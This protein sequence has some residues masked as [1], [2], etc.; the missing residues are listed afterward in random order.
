MATNPKKKAGP[1][2]GRPATK[3]KSAKA[4]VKKTKKVPAKAAKTGKARKPNRYNTLR[5]AI[6]QYCYRKYKHKCSN[7]EINRIYRELKMRYFDVD[8]SK[9]VSPSELAR[10][11][12]DKLGFKDKDN[13]PDDLKT[14]NWFDI[15]SVL[16]GNDK[17]FFKAGDRIEIQ[18]SGLAPTVRFDISELNKAYSDTLYPVMRKILDE[19]EAQF[20]QRAS[21][22]PFFAFDSKESNVKKRQF[23]WK[24]EIDS[25]AQAITPPTPPT[26]PQTPA[27]APEQPDDKD[28]EIA[29][30]QAREK[31]AQ[32]EEKAL[33]A[34]LDLIREGREL[35]KEGIITP[36][37]FKRNFM[38][39]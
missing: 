7:E 30:L 31:A 14:F 23:V 34:R 9:Q 22:P 24:L 25:G 35:L 19:Y 32:A 2:A 8:P 4:G 27:P 21:P 26:Q 29:L 10:T 6:S 11:I 13:V 15:E 18:F 16:R 12:D 5:R 36:D 1:K 20:G 28:K 17:L 33:R 38:D 3:G 37:E 39:V